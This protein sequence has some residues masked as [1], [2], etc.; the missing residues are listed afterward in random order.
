MDDNFDNDEELRNKFKQIKRNLQ[1][2]ERENL[3]L[4][5]SN[6]VLGID[7]EKKSVHQFDTTNSWQTAITNTDV[8]IFKSKG[9]LGIQQ[10]QLH[11][12]FTNAIGYRKLFPNSDSFFEIDTIFHPNGV[13]W[14]T[15]TETKLFERV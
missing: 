11:P 4:S 13:L 14:S 12:S 10:N 8:L 2:L 6:I 5:Q 9:S 15:S 7:F 1:K 3:M